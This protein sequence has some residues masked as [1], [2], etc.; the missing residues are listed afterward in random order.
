MSSGFRHISQGMAGATVAPRP[1][2]VNPAS[3]LSAGE[4]DRDMATT[5]APRTARVPLNSLICDI[6]SLTRAIIGRCAARVEAWTRYAARCV[7]SVLVAT[8]HNGPILG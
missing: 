6:A 8:S 5:S 3:G 7:N 4:H 2:L 1:T